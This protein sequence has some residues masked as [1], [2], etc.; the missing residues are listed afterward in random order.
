MTR[1]T[2]MKVSCLGIFILA[3]DRYSLKEQMLQMLLRKNIFNVS[4][5]HAIADVSS[6]FL[7]K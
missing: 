2:V 6:Y 3:L 5:K 1:A 7:Q 4:N